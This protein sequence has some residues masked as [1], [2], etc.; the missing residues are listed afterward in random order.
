MSREGEE[1]A[2][3]FAAPPEGY[4]IVPFYWW[5]GDKLTKERIEWQLEKMRGHAVSGLQINYAHG[6]EGGRSFGLTLESDPPL[7]SEKWW[8][9]FES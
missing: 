3:H 6:Y 1:L 7:F 2:R 4:G 8:E 5:L 9:L